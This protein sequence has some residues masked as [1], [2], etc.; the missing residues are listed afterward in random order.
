MIAEALPWTVALLGTTTLVSFALG[1]FLGAL[2]GWPRAPRVD[3]VA[4]AAA[5]GAPRHSRSSCSG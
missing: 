3:A 2:L 4:H 1:T 5:L